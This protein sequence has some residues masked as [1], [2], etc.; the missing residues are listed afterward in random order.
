[1]TASAFG[2]SGPLLLLLGGSVAVLQ[3]TQPCPPAWGV[4]N[5]PR[6]LPAGTRLEFLLQARDW[7]LLAELCQGDEALPA[8][9]PWLLPL[10]SVWSQRAPTPPLCQPSL[11]Q[12]GSLPSSTGISLQLVGNDTGGESKLEH[13]PQLPLWVLVR[14]GCAEPKCQNVFSSLHSTKK[15]PW[16]FLREDIPFRLEVHIWIRR[17]NSKH[18][19]FLWRRTG[20]SGY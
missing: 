3:Q 19:E 12:E 18:V 4:R 7:L 13:P 15:P 6:A 9:F 11:L 5:I 1:M 8:P 2:E 20:F 17:R 16:L 14:P 10:G